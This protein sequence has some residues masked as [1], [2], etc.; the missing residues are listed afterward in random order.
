[1]AISG[2]AWHGLI[3]AAWCVLL[4]G[5]GGGDSGGNQAVLITGFIRVVNSLPDSPT[6]NTGVSQFALSRVSFAQSTRLTQ[7][8]AN[9]YALNVQYT[10]AAGTIVSVINESLRLESDVEVSVFLLGDLDTVRTEMIVNPL[11]A[12]AVGQ[13]EFQVMQASENAGTVDVYLTDAAAPLAGATPLTL[14][15]EAASDLATID[16]GTN[17]R[18]RVTTAGTTTVLYDSGPFAIESEARPL[19]VLEDY[20]GPG[21]NGFRAVQVTNEAATTFPAEVLPG[22]LRIANMV[23]DHPA[24]DV[25]IGGTGGA[26]TFAAVPFDTIASRQQ[27]AAGTLAVTVTVAGDPSTVLLS[28]A[29]SLGSGES[30]TLVLSRSGAGVAGRFSLD[31]TRPISVQTQMQVVQATPAAGNIDVYL[32]AA[33]KTTAEVSPTFV[34]L[35]LQSVTS[36]APAAASYDVAVTPV[37]VKTVAAGPVPVVVDDG[38]IYSIYVSDAPGGGSPPQIVLGDDFD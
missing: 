33:G 15:F 23:A 11:P 37:G 13:A 34:N 1:V 12:I 20:F 4:G 18:L 6:L 25:Y 24:V 17:Y 38:G 14:A 28:G 29:A 35:P 36:G 7:L 3:I 27:F 32:L 16:A 5:C 31:N 26:P 19:F 8:P 9:D 2:S 10:N 22:A 30:R 21:G